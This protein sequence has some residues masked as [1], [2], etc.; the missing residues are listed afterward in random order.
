MHY[1]SPFDYVIIVLYFL[2]LVAMGFYLKRRASQSLEDY[3][4]GNRRMPWYLLGISGMAWSLDMTGTMLIV[5]FLYLMGPRGL[6]VEF[7][8]GANLVLIFMMLWTG[9]WHRRSMCMTGAEWNIFRFGSTAGGQAT[10]LIT[11]VATVVGLIIP[12]I[13]YMVKGDGLFLATFLPFRPFTCALVLIGVATLYTVVSGF[14]GVVYTDLLQC[15]IIVLA[16]IVVVISA[17][18]QINA[19]DGDLVSLAESVT[20]NP[21]WGSSVPHLH[22]PMP[23]AYKEFEPLLIVAMF[24]LI[25]NIM[26]GMGSGADPR[27]FGARSERDCGLL[28]FFWSN[29]MIFRW[30][31]MM[32]FAVLGLFLIHGM[33]PDQ[34]VLPQA[35]DIIHRHLGEIPKNRWH[36]VIADVI[37]TPQ[38]Y[39]GLVADLKNVLQDD[40]GNK[41]KMLSYDGT[42]NPERIVPAV[43]FQAIPLGARG[44]LFVALIA[45]SMSTFNSFINWGT[46]FITKDVYQAFVRPKASNRELILA[47]YAFGVLIVICGL[48]LGYTTNSIN[49]IWDWIT[50]GIGAGVALPTILRLYWWRFNS[51]GVVIGT[52]VGL[53]AAVFQ[54]AM[55]PD[56]GP[57]QKFLSLTA[58]GVA[59]A[60]VGTYLTPPT[61]RK[62]LEHFYR[63]TRPFG[64]WGPVKHV[65]GGEQR[66][67]MNREH[68]YDLICV[69]FALVYQVTLFLMPMQLILK[70]FRSFGVTAAIWFAC[71]VFLYQFW[72]RKLPPAG[73]ELETMAAIPAEPTLAAEPVIASSD[74]SSKG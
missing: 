29:L 38:R 39:P 69:P 7:R 36:D 17:V 67:Q 4:L 45:A 6:F 70:E 37:N 56:M 46:S 54:H 25:R 2:G 43:L 68:F 47:S 41:L 48:A 13:A 34:S 22:T 31:L 42:V 18:Q 58:I 50:M 16:V 52:V 35:V 26:G 60:L 57:W 55:Y 14:Y 62:V 65:L 33:F 27:Y 12:M 3:F 61:D 9:K 24:Y 32:S 71:L 23:A 74:Y 8:G 5:S 19:Y 28:T 15:G 11:V 66:R 40:W 44:L 21:Q 63:T 10:R 64:F 49:H 20:Q 53:T 51:G 59:G 73:A 72:Y 30:P 1:F